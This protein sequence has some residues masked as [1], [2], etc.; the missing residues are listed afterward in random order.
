MRLTMRIYKR[1]DP[2]LFAL[3]YSIPEE[4]NFK[5]EIK[6]ILKEYINK[7]EKQREL[8]N[9]ECNPLVSLPPKANFHINLDNE[10]DKEIIDFLKEIRIGRRNNFIKNIVRNAFPPIISV[11]Y[12]ESEIES[13]NINERRH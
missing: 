10:K 1:H 2:D 3:Y 12:T 11:Y 6:E 4:V 13:F 5:E 8:P 9:Y 7:T